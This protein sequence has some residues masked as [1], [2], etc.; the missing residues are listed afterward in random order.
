MNY[1]DILSGFHVTYRRTNNRGQLAARLFGIS[2]A[3]GEYVAFVDSDD[4]VSLNYHLP[5]LS[6]AKMH[7]ADIV[8]NGWAFHTQRTKRVC[9]NDTTMS[10]R[11]FCEGDAAL[12]FY[13]ENQGREHSY[14][15]V[16]NK[17]YRRSILLQAKSEIE[18]MGGADLRLTYSEDALINFF[19]FKY[20][21]RVINTNSGFYF[22]RI[23]SEQSIVSSSKE[24]LKNKIDSMALTI[25]IMKNNI[26][27]NMY[28]K[29]ILRNLE[30]WSQ[31]MARTHYTLAKA[32]RATEL[33]GYI[34]EKYKVKNNRRSTLKDGKVY[35]KSELL[36]EN[37][38]SIDSSLKELYYH[39]KP[40]TVFYEKRAKFI[41]RIIADM[42]QRL[43]YSKN[44]EFKIPKRKIGFR[45]RLL[46]N[47]IVYRLGMILFRKGS[48]IRAFL[49][50]HL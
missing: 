43:K 6:A 34:K 48:K 49:K 11:I 1:E 10:K 44:G 18:S 28:Y 46:H 24:S 41:A 13:T 7:R 25:D 31:L 22:Y 15:V 12:L 42:P 47:S 23:H 50:K 4:S 16:W 19:C 33:Y 9:I 38:A 20:A 27:N 35:A 21:K 45:N 36:G 40:T 8:F 14:Y 2:V 30:M 26:A 3:R 5:M 37:F 17:I 29:S 32:A 39:R